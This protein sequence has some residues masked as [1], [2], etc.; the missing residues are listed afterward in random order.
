MT[1]K[2]KVLSVAEVNCERMIRTYGIEICDHEAGILVTCIGYNEKLGC[3]CGH[4]P[5]VKQ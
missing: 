1:K 5:R 2:H 3:G 4:Y